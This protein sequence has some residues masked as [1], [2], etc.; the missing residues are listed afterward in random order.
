MKSYFFRLYLLLFSWNIICVP[1]LLGSQPDPNNGLFFIANKMEVKIDGRLVEWQGQKPVYLNQKNQLRYKQDDWAG[2]TDCSAK[3][4]LG[5]NDIGFI[6]AAETIDDSIAFPFS[7]SDVWGNDCIQFAVDVHDDNAPNFYQSDDREFV[8]TLVDSQAIVYEYTYTEHRKAGIRKYPAQVLVSGDT[9]RYE[10]VIPWQGLGIIGPFAGMHLGASVVFFDNDG[11]APRG[12]LEWTVG[13]TRKK[14]TLPFANILLFD[15]KINIVQAIPTQP[16]LSVNDTLTLWVYSRY[17][18]RKVTHRLFENDETFFRHSTRVKARKWTKLIIPPKYL[19]WGRL[20]LDVNSTRISQRFDILVWSKQLITQQIDYLT[21]QVQVFKNLKTIDPAVSI[22]VE[23]WVEW[24]E[25]KFA[26]AV[27]NFDFFD[28][29]NQAQKRIDQIPNFYMKK[30]VY[31]NREHRIVEQLYQSKREGKIRRYLLYLPSDFN[32]DK[33]YPLFM[34][35]HNGRGN[36]EESARKMGNILSEYDLPVIGLFPRG[37]PDLGITHFGLAEIMDCLTDISKKYPVDKNKIYLSGEGS[38][39]IEALL[40]AERFPDRFAAV[41][42]SFSKIDTSINVQNLKYLPVRIFGET[43]QDTENF[44]IVEKIQKIGGRARYSSLKHKD[45]VEIYSP[46]YFSW[47]LKQQRHQYPLKIE[48]R[49]KH[50]KPARTFWLEFISQENY[51]QPAF[52]EAVVDSNRLFVSTKNLL[53]FSILLDKLPASVQYPLRIIVNS[54]NRFVVSEKQVPKFTIYKDEKNWKQRKNPEI[55]LKKYPSV[56]G[57]LSAIFDK[58]V[59]FVYSTKHKNSEFNKITFNLAKQASKRGRNN[60]LNKFLI[61]DSVM[62][63]QTVNSNIIAFGNAEANAYLK[64]LFPKLPM[65]VYE[66]GLKFGNSY[67]DAEGCAGVYIFPNPQNPNYLI[68]VGV[69]PD[70]TGLKNIYKTWD[71][72]Y[73]NI[74]YGYDFLT[75]KN[76]VEKNKYHDWIDFGNFDN[77]WSVPWFQPHFRKGPKYWHRD[78]LVGLDANQLSLNSNW[79]GGGKA[80]FTWKIYTRMEF[81]YLRKKFNWKNSFYCAFGQISVEENENWRAPEKSTDIIDFDS[82]LKL[83]LKTFIDPYVAISLDTQFR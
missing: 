33:K 51:S 4:W 6:V 28:V 50:L 9:V 67:C 81:K 36:E 74:I 76:G 45:N 25:K 32:R 52:I 39:G 48:I 22:T 82:V 56:T 47:L 12:S 77:N 75:L 43:K 16:F 10:V 37:Y 58:P 60:Y 38:G 1:V 49:I 5:W 63:K 59:K 24:L 20:T 69:A 35:L 30:Q 17:Y 65:D 29:M 61:A 73:N 55:S 19:K 72:N 2:P 41:S 46:D 7:G 26:S 54:R 11:Q 8:V 66:N 14:F 3:F 57:P 44:Y 68:L 31:Y 34:Y 15:P 53:E 13:I 23:Y 18:R 62:E 80:N 78:I 64:K 79:K 21:Q 42:I 83:T 27:T 70:T 40:L 71:L